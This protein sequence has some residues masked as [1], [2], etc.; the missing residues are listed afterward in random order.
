M[1]TKLKIISELE[2]NHKG[3]HLRELSRLVN[4]G[5]PNVKRFLEIFKKAGLK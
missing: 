1:G 5:L 4:S 3:I 2:K